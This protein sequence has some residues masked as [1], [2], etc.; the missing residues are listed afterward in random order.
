MNPLERE[1]WLAL[2]QAYGSR[3][4]IRLDE[5]IR[6][7]LTGRNGQPMKRKSAQNQI[8]AGTFPVPVLHERILIRDVARWLHLE[9][10]KAA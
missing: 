3:P 4:T 2:G 5:F 6:D 8:Y 1:I 9:R 7:F 10:T